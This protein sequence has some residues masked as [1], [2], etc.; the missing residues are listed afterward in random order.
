MKEGD[1]RDHEARGAELRPEHRLPQCEPS[2]FSGALGVI[3]FGP[4]EGSS[5]HV[6]TARLGPHNPA[7]ALVK[8]G[9]GGRAVRAGRGSVSRRQVDLF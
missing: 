3:H 7:L 4:D 1:G 2:G 9:C 8:R 6:A 5:C